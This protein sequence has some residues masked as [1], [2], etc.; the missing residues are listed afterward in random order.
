[1]ALIRES[2]VMRRGTLY[3]LLWYRCPECQDVGFATRPV[4][5]APLPVDPESEETR[6]VAARS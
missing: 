4:A 6:T 3:C 5:D 2:V 1:M